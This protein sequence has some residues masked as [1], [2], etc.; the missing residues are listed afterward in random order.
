VFCF[1]H[2]GKQSGLVRVSTAE[3]IGG[4]EKM[5]ASQSRV[6]RRGPSGWGG[7]TQRH[8]AWGGVEMVGG[9]LEH[10][11]H[12]GS[13]RPERNGGGSPDTGSLASACGS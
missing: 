2:R 10:A 9:G 3:G 13:G 12:S 6:H 4:G 8:G 11:I 5:A 1:F 7:S